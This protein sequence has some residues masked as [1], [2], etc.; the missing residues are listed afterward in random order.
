MISINKKMEI[1]SRFQILKYFFSIFGLTEYISSETGIYEI[2]LYSLFVLPVFLFMIIYS[3]VN[4][5]VF[6]LRLIGTQ[7]LAYI[8]IIMVGSQF[9]FLENA[10]NQILTVVTFVLSLSFGIL[11]VRDA[12]KEIKQREEIE[13]LAG[14]L[15]IS[16]QG[17]VN[18]IHFMNHQIKGRFGT[19]KNIFAELLTDDYGV[20]PESS[21]FMLQKGLEETNLGVEYVQSILKGASAENGSIPFDMKALDFKNIVEDTFNGQKEKAEKKGLKINISIGEGEYGLNGDLL[22]L[23][24][25]VRNLIDNS[26]NYTPTGE[27]DVSLEYK[28]NK[29]VLKVKDTGVGLTDSDKQKLFKSGGRGEE[30][31][32]VNVNSTG[33]GLAFVK[34]VIEAHKGCV[35]AESE[36]RGK[37][38]SFFIELPIN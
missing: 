13:R 7:L 23:S 36:G 16:N 27:I 10:T 6:N 1:S 14:S 20:M 35:W 9:F 26:I 24:E 22:Q 29:I 30:S 32:K 18:L 5:K 3:I 4:L 11:L 17:Q 28:N 33:Y 12:R 8:M 34:G 31:L 15:K 21:K 25:A 38:S 19:A 37:G 2:N